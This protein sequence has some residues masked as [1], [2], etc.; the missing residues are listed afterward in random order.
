M[1][2]PFN[3][4][5]DRQSAL[6]LR[7]A[8]LVA[9]ERFGELSDSER[10]EL[11]LWLTEKEENK[12]WKD[13]LSEPDYISQLID[14]YQSYEAN[15]EDSLAAFHARH[16][17]EVAVVTF[18]RRIPTR[19]WW[20][21]AAVVIP[22]MVASIWFSGR[23][24]TPQ[25]IAKSGAAEVQPGRNTA[26]LTLGNGNHI[27]LDTGMSGQVVQDGSVL[28][29]YGSGQVAYNAHKHEVK[30]VEY[31]TLSTARGGQYQV[32]LP[33]GT[34][35]W[36]NAVSSIRY[37]T[38]FKGNERK[39]EMTGEAYF[40]VVA[41]KDQ[42]FV[43]AVNGMDVKVLGT[44]FD[45]MAYPEEGN[46]KTTLVQGAI[47]VE[48]GNDQRLLMPADQA[49]VGNDGAL[50]VASQVDVESVIAWKLGF[51]QFNHID[52]Q[53]MMRQIARWYDVEIVY[54]RE[55]LSGE[56]GGR[57]SRKLNLSELISLLEGNGA[58]RFKIEGR[59]LI[60]LP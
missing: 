45:I 36:L 15:V 11:S 9:K 7:I 30:A 27:L 47:K 38:S 25:A 34:K 58:G 13:Q 59:K 3:E 31:N 33:D 39:V 57:I 26:T 10:E 43:V 29:H 46:K 23:H 2:S 24:L 55:D 48:N 56:Y 54:Q 19:G 41:R 14:S 49:I 8:C 28:A 32:V 51:F 5:E 6:I 42:P 20:A 35:V 50:S 12:I 22:L 52:L 40:E 4:P 37:P 60:V 16:F 18:R 17:K 21:A 53:T 44:E 1:I